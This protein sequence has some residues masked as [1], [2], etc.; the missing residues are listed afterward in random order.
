MPRQAPLI[1]D[2]TPADAARLVELW[3]MATPAGMGPPPAREDTERVLA[4]LAAE[5][6]ERLLVA[7]VEG[8]VVAMI[9]LSRGPM[10]P[11]MME[12]AVH[13]SFLLVLPQLRRHGYGHALMEATLAWADEKDIHHITALTDVNR[14]TNRFFARLGLTT[15]ATV[16]HT[17]VAG[18]RK[19]LTSERAR[20][21]GGNRQLVKVLAQRRSMR[22]RQASS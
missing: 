11:L 15:L 14:E 6:D 19:K 21:G 20:V 12:P 2:A 16:R 3:E 1:R 17:S 7:E 8:L 4:N 13:T 9:K 10:T 5:P 22:R 18:L